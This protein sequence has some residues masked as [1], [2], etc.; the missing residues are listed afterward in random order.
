MATDLSDV[1]LPAPD[2]A[3]TGRVG[4]TVAA[5]VFEALDENAVF[6]LVSLLSAHLTPPP[7]GALACCSAAMRDG[8]SLAREEARCCADHALRAELASYRW[9]K[10]VIQCIKGGVLRLSVNGEAVTGLDLA[11]LVRFAAVAGAREL[12]LRHN[13][14]GRQGLRVI[15]LSASR[16]GLDSLHVL[17]L[18]HNFIGDDGIEQLADSMQLGGFAQLRELNLSSN[19]F[20]DR[21]LKALCDSFAS[22]SVLGHLVCLRLAGNQNIDTGGV[23]TLAAVL[24]HAGALPSLKHLVIPSGFERNA[25]LLGACREHRITLQ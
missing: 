18:S 14:L 5:E 20:G 16:G 11:P 3:A 25:L 6:T 10:K 17:V 7:L 2:A 12:K 1:P 8:S 22:P 23:Q 19:C 21:G 13:Y 9:G 15:S 24:A 4:H